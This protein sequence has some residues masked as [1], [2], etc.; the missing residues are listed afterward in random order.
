MSIISTEVICCETYDE[1][2]WIKLMRQTYTDSAPFYWATESH[3]CYESSVDSS[4][5]DLGKIIAYFERRIISRKEVLN[6]LPQDNVEVRKVYEHHIDVIQ[7][8]IDKIKKAAADTME[9]SRPSPNSQMD[10]MQVSGK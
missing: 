1:G 2:G 4:N 7:R 9:I 5:E 3:L 10:A 8:F 6:T